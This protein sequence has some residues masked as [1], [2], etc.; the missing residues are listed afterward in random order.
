MEVFYE[1]TMSSGAKF[2]IT[3]QI[4]DLIKKAV[5]E[6]EEYLFLEDEFSLISINDVISIKHIGKA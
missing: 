5:K 4:V 3:K 6:K 2:L 1:L